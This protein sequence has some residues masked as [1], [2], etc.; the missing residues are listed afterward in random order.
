MAFPFELVLEALGGS[1]TVAIAELAGRGP[2]G[3]VF[4]A[5]VDAVGVM[6]DKRQ[7]VR[8]PNNEKITSTRSF[9]GPPG[10][11]GKVGAEV[12]Y[13]G[14]TSTVV[15]RTDHDGGGAETPDHVELNLA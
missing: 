13:A 10:T 6:V 7:L 14:V 15:G 8:G 2:R 9:Y 3:N 4:A 11:P 12:T 1:H 5:P